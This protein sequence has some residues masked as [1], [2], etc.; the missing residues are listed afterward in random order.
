MIKI[1]NEAVLIAAEA[2]KISGILAPEG[3]HDLTFE[4]LARVV[5]SA[6]IPYLKIEKN[7]L[8]SSSRG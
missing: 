3:R 8:D 6:S 5:L 2:L 7:G 4:N 1:T